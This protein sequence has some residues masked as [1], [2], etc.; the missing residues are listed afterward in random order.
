MN[1]LH[2]CKVVAGNDTQRWLI[3]QKNEREKEAENANENGLTLFFT[4]HQEKK[5][6]ITLQVS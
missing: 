3:E 2:F 1:Y 6:N 5:E 4:N